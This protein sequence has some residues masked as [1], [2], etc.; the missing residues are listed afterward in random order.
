MR[1]I[2]ETLLVEPVALHQTREVRVGIVGYGTVGR[3]TAEILALNAGEIQRRT[4]GV[5]IRVTRLCRKGAGSSEAGVNGV[6]VVPDWEQV[7]NADNVDIVVEAMG[8]TGL[9][10]AIEC[11]SA[12]GTPTN[13][14]VKIADNEG[15]ALLV[16]WTLNG[17]PV[18]TN[19]IPASAGPARHSDNAAATAKP[20]TL[21]NPV[22]VS[23]SAER[24]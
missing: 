14:M 21:T 23:L 5:S 1:T 8:G 12:T 19:Q 7:V 9:P 4:D 22:I 13:L 18:Q 16:I 6:A 24:S 17:T 2:E 11:S 15:D 3:A 10:H 20:R